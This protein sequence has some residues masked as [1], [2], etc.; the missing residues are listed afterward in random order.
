MSELIPIFS[1]I[2]T[3]LWWI[4]LAV[5]FIGLVMAFT[6]RN[7]P[8]EYFSEEGQT[9]AM[10]QNLIGRTLLKGGAT[11][12]FMTTAVLLLYRLL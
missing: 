3:V 12:V 1:T 5:G 9:R 4:G 6:Y 10:S 8:T 7:L 11:L 2:L